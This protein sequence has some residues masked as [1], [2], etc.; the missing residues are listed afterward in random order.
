MI[1]VDKANTNVKDSQAHI[2]IKKNGDNYGI[3]KDGSWKD[4]KGANPPKL[5][6]EEINFL[7][8][9]KWGIPQ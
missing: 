3:N 5:T 2:T 1:R 6:N 4:L 8:Q 9:N 7:K